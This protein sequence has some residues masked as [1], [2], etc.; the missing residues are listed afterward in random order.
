MGRR[1]RRAWRIGAG[2]EA[3][4]YAAV[5]L[6][7]GELLAA[8]QWRAPRG[9]DAA[10]REALARCRREAEIASR[11]PP[12]PHVVAHL[13]SE[14]HDG[15]GGEDGGANAVGEGAQQLT[16]LMEFC[17]GGTAAALARALGGVPEPALRAL[18]RQLLL[19]LEFLHSH[20]VAHRDLKALNCLLVTDAPP[21]PP[22]RARR[23]P[24]TAAAATRPAAAAAGV[25]AVGALVLKLGDFGMRARARRAR[26]DR[27]LSARAPPP[28]ARRCGPPP[29]LRSEHGDLGADAWR[30]CGVWSLGCTL[31]ELASGRP[32]W[33]G[34][35][36]LAER[37]ANA[38]SG[39]RARARARRERRCGAAP[40]SDS[41]H[42]LAL[43]IAAT[44]A[45]PRA[46]PALSELGRD[47]LRQCLNRDPSE[48]QLPEQL[49]RHPFVALPPVTL[50][51]PPTAPSPPTS[52][53]ALTAPAHAVGGRAAAA[54]AD[55]RTAAQGTTR[56]ALVGPRR[57]RALA[58]ARSLSPSSSAAARDGS[59]ARLAARLAER[60][61]ARVLAESARA[62]AASRAT[63]ATARLMRARPRPR[64]DGGGWTTPDG[65]GGGSGGGGGANEG[66]LF[67]RY[68]PHAASRLAAR[69][70]V[71]LATR[72]AVRLAPHASPRATSPATV[73]PIAAE[74]DADAQADEGPG[75]RRSRRAQL[76]PPR[77]RR[78]PSLCRRSRSRHS[79]RRLGRRR[80]R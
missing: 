15:D 38:A 61:A 25:D 19:G 60:L 37:G 22:P 58:R 43:A 56:E 76:P 57:P 68:A 48:R 53:A 64:I 9:G 52:R 44:D 4:V 78:A 12:H 41:P 11:L 62:T 72:L 69:L 3:E 20:G 51:P 40:R 26:P 36:E 30:R 18:A 21:P 10:Q 65:G 1:W 46:P 42:A 7:S 79:P 49:L 75:G 17:A 70:A 31:I 35:A 45:A 14:L 73:V 13:G 66:G 77:R 23:Q 5:D 74:A 67:A 54:V 28:P 63:Q 50:Q 33:G 29:A 2:R 39:R 16:V 80:A 47:F 55:A 71:R 8:K 32:P 34:G 24:P 59:G 6:D 27:M